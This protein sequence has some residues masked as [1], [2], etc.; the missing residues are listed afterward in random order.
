M[1]TSFFVSAI[2]FQSTQ[3]STDLKVSLIPTARMTAGFFGVFEGVPQREDDKQRFKEFTGSDTYFLWQSSRSPLSRL[4]HIRYSDPSARKVS[5][6]QLATQLFDVMEKMANNETLGGS[7]KEKFAKKFTDRSV[8]EMKVSGYEGWLDRHV[9]TET[10]STRRY[11]AW[12][13]EKEQWVWEV[14]YPTAIKGLDDVVSQLMA[15]A[16]VIKLEPGDAAAVPLLPQRI[17]DTTVSISSPGVLDV[18]YRKSLGIGTGL[19][20]GL[21]ASCQMGPQFSL[22][23][24]VDSGYSTKPGESER[25]CRSFEKSL[26]ENDE[27]EVSATKVLPFSKDGYDGHVYRAAYSQFGDKMYQLSVVASNG[28]KHAIVHLI[29]GEVNGG[30]SKADEILATLKFR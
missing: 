19:P 7:L 13:D 1:L 25:L 28:S 27:F 2:A 24:Y 22:T 26:R 4:T 21:T 23:A 16:T 20:D 6:K 3:T 14:V 17:P 18:F 5:T 8:K 29:V 12:G 9:D 30:K 11:L 10:G 15:T